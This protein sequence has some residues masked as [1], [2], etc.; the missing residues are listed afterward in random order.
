MQ[1]NIAM[2]KKTLF[3]I[4]ISSLFP[5]WAISQCKL[6][7]PFLIS[8]DSITACPEGE[9]HLVFHDEFDGN[10][11][12]L[13]KW[14]TS[15]SSPP[16]FDRTLWQNCTREL[17]YYT[18]S[19]FVF[20]NGILQI[21]AKAEPI[22][23]QG[24][25]EGDDTI[26]C[27]NGE[28]ILFLPGEEFSEE[29]DFTSGRIEAVDSFFAS[30]KENFIMEIRC[31]VP[32]G[33]GLWP[34]FWTWHIDEIDVF[35]YFGT[36][37]GCETGSS[38]HFQSAYIKSPGGSDNTCTV[39]YNPPSVGDLTE[40]FHVY[41][42]EVTEWYKKWFFDGTKIVTAPRF[43]TLPGP[44]PISNDCGVLLPSNQ[45]Y[46]E[47]SLFVNLEEGR[48]FR[49]IANL[50]IHPACTPEDITGLPAKFEIDYIRVYKRT[51]EDDEQNLCYYELEGQETLCYGEKYDFVL[52]SNVK[53]IEI[54]WTT[55][56]NLSVDNTNEGNPVT[57]SVISSEGE[58]GWIQAEVLGVG[59][60]CPDSVF[61]I[62]VETYVPF[63]GI[64][65]F[66]NSNQQ[67]LY[68]VNFVPE[69]YSHVV[70]NNTTIESWEYVGGSGYVSYTPG[71]NE[72]HVYTPT[73]GFFQFR[74]YGIAEGCGEVS[75][76]FTFICYGRGE[77]YTVSPNPAT[78]EIKISVLAPEQ[79]IS[80]VN[81][82]GSSETLIIS[83]LI[84]GI[85]I[86]DVNSG[87]LIN[88]NDYSTF[89]HETTINVGNLNPGNYML[90]IF[91]KDGLKET[92]SFIKI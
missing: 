61:T 72:F 48:Y 33:V 81:E 29:F 10:T 54:K 68:S 20:Q 39:T 53:D 46:A 55:S 83:P 49:P 23:Y 12:D 41:S 22:I 32:K 37:P 16:P 4:L 44:I 75:R 38:T 66:D 91:R 70:L 64:I 19:N 58:N 13:S 56:S 67:T 6:K 87:T 65:N 21:I 52:N 89:L 17:Q 78:S 34:A 11:L 85:K 8:S 59:E 71:S 30:P 84:K 45:V 77:A 69:N 15:T 5:T 79:T 63:S 2:A 1:K 57:V 88:Q 86:F 35:E 92:Y 82:G 40:D 51:R 3:F 18:D 50:A 60:F 36:K 24:I 73:N 31:R 62:N 42:V 74:A 14:K 90:E 76:L 28:E 25:I 26:T 9:Y 27:N 43:Y 80:Y 7:D 47:D